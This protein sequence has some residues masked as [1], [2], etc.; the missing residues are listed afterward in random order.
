[1]IKNYHTFNKFVIHMLHAFVCK[2]NVNFNSLVLN[3][4]SVLIFNTEHVI[5]N[6]TLDC[7]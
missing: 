1:M 2:E 7:K 4:T 3:Q 5:K 6:N